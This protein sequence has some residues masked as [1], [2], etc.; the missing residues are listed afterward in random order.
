VQWHSLAD[1]GELASL[2]RLLAALPGK[3]L[4]EEASRA[5]IP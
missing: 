2:C 1:A 4:H 5:A 3:A